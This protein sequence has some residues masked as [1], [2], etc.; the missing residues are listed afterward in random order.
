VYQEQ[1][2]QSSP[3]ALHGCLS[4][5]L[6]AGAPASGEYCLD[7]LAQA[8]DLV[9]HGE[10]AEQ[11]M[12]LYAVT[13]AAM[14]DEEFDFHPLLPDDETDIADRTAALADW[15]TG[16]LAGF[17]H[18]SVGEDKSAPALSAE[19]SDILRD[20]AAIAQAGVDEEEDEEE[21]E[22][23]YMELLEYL[24]FA[25]LN[26]YMDCSVAERESPGTGL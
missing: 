18:A 26:V 14:Q 3:S 20:F 25:A 16:F 7:A 10:L 23:S 17:A 4:G 9:L 11:V 2:V 15:C 19:S 13:G 8:R 12:Q 21:S 1:G 6:S 22:N 5:L 24:R